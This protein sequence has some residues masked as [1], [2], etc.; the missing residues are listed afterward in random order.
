MFIDRARVLLVEDDAGLRVGL[1]A[2]LAQAGYEVRTAW[3]GVSAL[4]EIGL[5]APDLIVSE[6]DMPRMSGFDLLW[7]VS[8][9]LPEIR[10]IAMSGACS[11]K[12]RIRD[13]VTADGFYEK[14]LI[15]S[16]YFSW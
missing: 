12:K 4:E 6:L 15:R 14:E 13:S 8:R 11:S 2:L 10:L 3:D 9:Q 16:F 7:L 1:S 5:S